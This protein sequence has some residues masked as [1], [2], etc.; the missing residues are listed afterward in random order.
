MAR[1]SPGSLDQGVAILRKTGTDDGAGGTTDTWATVSTVWAS[2]LPK[3]GVEGVAAMQAR[4]ATTYDVM[5]RSGVDVAST[6]RLLWSGRILKIDS[7]PPPGRDLYRALV[8]VED[9]TRSE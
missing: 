5:M 4:E 8:A 9:I 1:F 3:S 6:D 7:A 2:V